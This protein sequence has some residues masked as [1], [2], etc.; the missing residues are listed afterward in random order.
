MD[1][2]DEWSQALDELFGIEL[3]P[4]ERRALWTRVRAAHER[5]LSAQYSR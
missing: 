2:A 5:W 4:E 1:A 3:A